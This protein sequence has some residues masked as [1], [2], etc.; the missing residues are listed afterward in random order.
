MKNKKN[1]MDG[2]YKAM[3]YGAIAQLSRN[4]RINKA[5]KV[6]FGVGATAIVSN[7]IWCFIKLLFLP[8]YIF[9]LFFIWVPLKYL[10]KLFK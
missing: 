8:L 7:G 1:K 4:K 3:G 2:A 6:A 10:G 5:G 9:Y